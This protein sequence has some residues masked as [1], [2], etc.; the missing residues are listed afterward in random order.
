MAGS[1]EEQ[2]TQADRFGEVL[3]LQ[4]G[5]AEL[6]C[7]KVDRTAMADKL[8]R[9]DRLAGAAAAQILE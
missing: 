8:E 6:G 5:K 1:F 3:W 4:V 9:E 7:W 2:R